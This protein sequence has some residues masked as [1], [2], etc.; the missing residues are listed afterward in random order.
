[1]AAAIMR[2]FDVHTDLIDAKI[3]IDFL[4]AYGDRDDDNQLVGDAITHQGRKALGLCRVLPLKDRAKGAGDAE[5][6][7][8][9]DY[10][11]NA[12]EAEQASL[13]DHELTHIQVKKKNGNVVTDDLMRPALKMRKHDVEVG[14]F[15]Q[16]AERHGVNSQECRQSRAIADQYGQYLWPEIAGTVGVQAGRFQ[17]LEVVK[18]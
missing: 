5:I 6:M 3:K 18:A 15:I 13:L 2:R 4:F 17:R 8:N 14:W 9:H 11:E 12:P 10:W 1:M 16:V 7:L